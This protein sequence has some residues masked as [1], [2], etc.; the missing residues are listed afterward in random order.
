MTIQNIVFDSKYGYDEMYFRGGLPFGNYLKINKGER[1]SLDTYFN[2]LDVGVLKK[3]TSATKISVCLQIT[4][5]ARLSL[6]TYDGENEKIVAQKTDTGCAFLETKLDSIPENVILYPVIEAECDLSFLGGEYLCDAVPSK[7]NIAIAI[8]TYKRESAVLKNIEVLRTLKGTINTVYVV[9]N[10]QSLDVKGDDYIKILPNKNLGGSGG[11]TRGLIE[12][13]NG[14]HEHV[15]LMDDDIEINKESIFRMASIVSILKNECKNAHISASM[16]PLSKP[17]MQF[18]AGARFNGQHIESFKQGLD[19]REKI[20]LVKNLKADRVEYGAWWCFLLPLS[21]IDSF[22]LPLPLFI[23]FDDVEY[24][25]RCC[26][27]APIITSN[28]LCVIHED[29]DAKYSPHLEYYTIRNQLITLATQGKKGALNGILR[30]AKVSAKHLFL[31]RY[32]LMP[33]IFKAFEDFLQG[34]SLLLNT[35][36]EK[37]NREIMS[38]APKAKPLSE[39]DGWE[40]ELR[41]PYEPK[42]RC[43]FSKLF[44]ALTLGAHLIPS[45]MLK[46]E[47][48]AFPLSNAKVG[49]AYLRKKTIQYQLGSDFGYAY[50]RS[51][52]S[53]F[54]WFFKCFSLSFKLLF[55]YGRA[56]RS[57]K[58]SK[59]LLTSYTFWKKHLEL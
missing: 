10:G 57:F 43:F 38:L 40:N 39:L 55:K 7:T 25:T 48:S 53:F 46:K 32:D 26:K 51:V 24:G 50:N 34:A 47:I 29:F 4:G 5:T 36:E 49:S 6:C 28:G 41:A 9:D 23:K 56:K 44:Q 45:F 42:R 8:C 30:L 52:K 21:D 1:V 2:S 16:L 22:G 14:G 31:Y 13:K 35:D 59:A 54:K 27:N 20:S 11:F 37:L 33:L 19:L 58:N 3:Y 17:Y 15:I 12:A 18:E